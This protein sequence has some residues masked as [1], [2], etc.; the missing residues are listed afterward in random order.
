MTLTPEEL[1][2]ISTTISIRLIGHIIDKNP[3]DVDFINTLEYHVDW[4]ENNFIVH[5]RN[6]GREWVTIISKE[7]FNIRRRYI[8]IIA[9]LE[10]LEWEPR[11]IGY[12]RACDELENFNI[13]QKYITE[14]EKID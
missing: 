14:L 6:N 1:I 2:I 8:A 4:I 11:S 7:N 10:K 5:V 13:Q 9:E 12:L 3:I